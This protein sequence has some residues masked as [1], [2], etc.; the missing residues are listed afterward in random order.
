MRCYISLLL[1]LIF[2]LDFNTHCMAQVSQDVPAD[3]Y[4]MVKTNMKVSY[5]YTNGSVSDHFNARVSYEFF[6]NR[7][8]TLTANTNYNSLYT[9]FSA[10]ALPSGYDP[11]QMEM[12]KT[13][14]YGQLGLSCSFRSRLFGRHFMAFGMMS[15]DWGDRRFQR[16]SGI[17]M[18]VFMLRVN[19]NTQ[20]GIGPLVL[21]NSTSKV[22][23]FLV[24]IYR[25]RFNN[26][27]AVNLYGGMFGLDYTPTTSDLITIG[28]DIDVR[29]FYFCPGHPELPERCRYTNTNFRPGIK[30]KR[31]LA[32]NFYGEVQGGVILKMSSRVT[33]ISGTKRYFDLP[34]PTRPFIQFTLS[35]AR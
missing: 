22:P 5:D 25:H 3:S 35:Y 14:I 30:Y 6:K 13:H 15:T 31:R 18:G 21:L 20:F 26:R 32:T 8:F 33:G 24:F 34:M 16:V 23:A 11:R 19:R 2:T 4:G 17:A 7:R 29:S 9:D 28:G 1:F 10:D 12:N 27:W